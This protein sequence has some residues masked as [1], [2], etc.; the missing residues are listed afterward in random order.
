MTD[1]GGWIYT[2]FR[3]DGGPSDD[4]GLADGHI[5][6][7]PA[8]GSVDASPLLCTGRRRTLN[9]GLM[10]W[11]NHGVMYWVSESGRRRR[12]RVWVARWCGDVRADGFRRDGWE[13]VG[14]GCQAVTGTGETLGGGG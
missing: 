14:D 7:R 10:Y 12:G 4:C 3:R 1:V 2:T 13:A 9:H 5:P 11:V 8:L 6:G